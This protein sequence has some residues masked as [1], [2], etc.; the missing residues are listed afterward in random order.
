MI[1]PSVLFSIPGAKSCSSSDDIFFDAESRVDSPV[2]CAGAGSRGGGLSSDML[3]PASFGSLRSL[4]NVDESSGSE[5]DDCVTAATEEGY[6]GSGGVTRRAT[7][8]AGS[9]P[10]PTVSRPVDF[11]SL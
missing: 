5:A 7:F 11:C 2:L 9:P 8:S 1:N 3:Q 4:A 6:P 10:T